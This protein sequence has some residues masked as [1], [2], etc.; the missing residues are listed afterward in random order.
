MENAPTQKMVKHTQTIR[1]Q[2][3]TNFLNVFGHFVRLALKGLTNKEKIME[4]KCLEYTTN[5][6]ATS[7]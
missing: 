2:R 3:P 1:W 7:S 4:D 5:N 6:N